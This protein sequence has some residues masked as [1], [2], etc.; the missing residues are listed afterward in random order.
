MIR[1]LEYPPKGYNAVDSLTLL[2]KINEIID[3]IT[4][5]PAPYLVCPHCG[6]EKWES[7]HSATLMGGPMNYYTY[8]C[9][10]CGNH[11]KVR[12]IKRTDPKVYLGPEDE[13]V[14]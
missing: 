9:S 2:G 4:S 11:T 12:R 6:G 13:I 1:K 7:T 8:T 5:K 10:N 14:K 3:A